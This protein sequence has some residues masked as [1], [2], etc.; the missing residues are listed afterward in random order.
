MGG[1]AGTLKAMESLRGILPQLCDDREA[2]TRTALVIEM[3]QVL[4][5]TETAR[6]PHSS[7]MVSMF[8]EFR[9]KM[10]ATRGQLDELSRVIDRITAITTLAAA[11]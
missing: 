3:T 5:N 10:A 8:A 11:A 6:I 4:G 2:I 1:S 7:A 9:T